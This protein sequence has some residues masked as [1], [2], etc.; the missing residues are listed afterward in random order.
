MKRSLAQRWRSRGGRRIRIVL[1]FDDI[2][3]F[4][5]ALLSLS[6][7][8]LADLGWTFADRKR[9]L[10][11]FLACGKKAQGIAPEKVGET[12]IELSLPQRDV[13]RLRRFARRELPRTAT[14]ARVITRVLNALDQQR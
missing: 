11:Y 9:L 6:P 8:E 5:L 13:A 1:A 4:A 12:P 10:G 14:N 2:M 7:A 3:E